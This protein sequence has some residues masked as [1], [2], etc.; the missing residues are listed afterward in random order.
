MNTATLIGLGIF[1][2]IIFG[3]L[4]AGWFAVCWVIQDK[5]EA[6][7][8]RRL[9]FTGL[10]IYLAPFIG[11]GLICLCYGL[12]VQPKIIEPKE[13]P[14]MT[15]EEMQKTLDKH[16]HDLVEHFANVDHKQVYHPETNQPGD[17]VT[18][19]EFVDINGIV[20]MMLDLENSK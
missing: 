4:V 5:L 16:M 19:R 3:F 7:Y 2:C 8:E 20:N 9:P 6:K 10:S 14:A 15:K 17:Y 18:H 13:D 1:C 11:V 12:V